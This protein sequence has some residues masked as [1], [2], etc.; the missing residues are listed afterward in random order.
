MLSCAERNSE[1]AVTPFDVHWTIERLLRSHSQDK[2]QPTAPAGHGTGVAVS[3]TL[4]V[5]LACVCRHTERDI[6]I[7]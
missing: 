1:R 4:R 6:T 3:G 5:P 2:G 7:S